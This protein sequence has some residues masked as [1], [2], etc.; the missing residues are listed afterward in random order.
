MRGGDPREIA[1]LAT[2]DIV[3]VESSGENPRVTGGLFS[4]K[5]SSTVEK[6]CD[7]DNY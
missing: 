7:S 3:K 1:T 6:E 5:R 4:Q 2:R